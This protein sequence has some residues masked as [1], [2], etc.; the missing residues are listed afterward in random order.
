MEYPEEKKESI[1]VLRMNIMNIRAGAVK[2]SLDKFRDNDV[3]LYCAFFWRP[4]H[5]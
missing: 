5:T 1:T 4:L 3:P 2:L